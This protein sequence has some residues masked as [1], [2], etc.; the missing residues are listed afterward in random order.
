M[1][2]KVSHRTTLIPM[3]QRHL[4]VNSYDVII[5]NGW[6]RT[7]CASEIAVTAADADPWSGSM[8]WCGLKIAGSAHHWSEH[9]RECFFYQLCKCNTYCMMKIYFRLL[10]HAAKWAFSTRMPNIDSGLKWYSIMQKVHDR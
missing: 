4:L 9:R 10:K 3:K 7:N 6:M 5:N 2:P 8:D 1:W